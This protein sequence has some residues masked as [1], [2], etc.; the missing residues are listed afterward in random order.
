M[1]CC[2]DRLRADGVQHQGDVLAALA[3]ENSDVPL[4]LPHQVLGSQCECRSRGTRAA[5]LFS[6]PLDFLTDHL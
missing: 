5:G 2:G 6:A 1:R 4:Q 3:L